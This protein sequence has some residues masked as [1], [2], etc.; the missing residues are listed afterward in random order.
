MYFKIKCNNKTYPKWWNILLNDLCDYFLR[1]WDWKSTWFTLFTWDL[2]PIDILRSPHLMFTTFPGR[3]DHLRTT[4][5]YGSDEHHEP[6]TGQFIKLTDSLR[7]W[8]RRYWSLDALIFMHEF[9]P[10][11]KAPCVYF[12][13]LTQ[14]FWPCFMFL[15]STEVLSF[16]PYHSPKLW[17]WVQNYRRSIIAAGK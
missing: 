6:G 4:G 17:Q 2:V 13:S 3:E 12:M 16:L 11:K 1:I 15:D 5:W 14:H 7:G 9:W 8:Y 10:I